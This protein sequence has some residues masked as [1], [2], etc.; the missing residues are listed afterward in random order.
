M[1]DYWDNE[2]VK[3]LSGSASPSM[4]VEK[5]AKLIYELTMTPEM[6]EME[7]LEIGCGPCVH[8]RH[9]ANVYDGWRTKYTGIDLSPTAIKWAQDAGLNAICGDAFTHK[10]DKKFDCFIFLDCLEHIFNHEALSEVVKDNANGTPFIFGN[11]PL[12]CQAHAQEVERMLSIK[13]IVKFCSAIGNTHFDYEIYG[14]YGLP[15]AR[16]TAS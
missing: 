1:L 2:W 13:D 15:Y 9:L 4:N 14:S 12:Y 10:F 8:A 3:R 16:F 11:I 6:A 7:K 5:M